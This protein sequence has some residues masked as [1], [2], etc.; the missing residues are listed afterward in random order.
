M[1]PQVVVIPIAD[2]DFDPSETGVP[3]KLLTEAG[4]KVVFATQNGAPGVADPLMLTGEGLDPWGWV[5]VV[6]KVKLVGL[7]MRADCN[8]RAAYAD[9]VKSQEFQHP[10]KYKDLKVGDYDGLILPGGHAK[11]VRPYL[12]DKDLQSFVADFFD[13][14]KPIA[15]VCHGVLVASRSVSKQTGKSS[16]YGYRTTALT[17]KLESTAWCLTKYFARFWDPNYYRTY[18]EGPNDPYGDMGVEQE[19]KRALKS[20]DDFEDVPKTAPDHFRKASGMFRDTPTDHRPSWVVTS[21]HYVS[22]RWP[23]DVH[24]MTT[25]FMSKLR[26]E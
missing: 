6:K 18:L 17:W 2:T 10:L 12:E 16:L 24:S 26:G 3:W 4:Y 7:F 1:S 9:M 22:A 15:A 14:K 25:T 21:D 5:P 23:G 8:A 20:P 11:G 19:V 13:A